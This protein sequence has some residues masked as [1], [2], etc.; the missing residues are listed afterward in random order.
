MNQ[1]LIHRLQSLARNSDAIVAVAVIGMLFLMV[2]PLNAFML[3]MFLVL[4]IGFSIGLLLI[5]INTKRV[6][7]FSV[8]PTVLLILTLFRLSLNVA[9]TR[10][11]LSHGHEGV[12]AAGKVIESFGNF[13][14]EGN[15]VVGL[16]VFVILVIINFIVITKGAGRISE[17][18]A[19]FTLDALPGKQMAIDADLNAGIIND[20]EAKRRRQEV[21]SEADFYGAMD[22][23]SKF[24]RGD[25]IAG[26]LVTIVNIIGGLI[27]GVVQKN[28]DVALAAKNYTLLTVGDGLVAQVPALIISTAAGLWVTRAGSTA[29]TFG[30]DIS[31]QLFVNEKLFYI[32]A[33]VLLLLGIVLSGTF[34]PFAALAGLVGGTGYLIK[35][36]KEDKLQK[37]A[38]NA[39]DEELSKKGKNVE[40][41]GTVESLSL[42]VG[43][44]LISIVDNKE[45]GD[46]LDRIQSLRKQFA[47]DLGI[48][49]PALNIRDNLQLKPGEYIVL[50]KGIEIG[51]GDLMVDHFMA[52]DP[53]GIT[54]RID[55]IETKEPVFGLDALWIHENN[56]ELA[57][58]AG[59]TVVD[60]STIIATHMTEVIRKNASE[61]VGRQEVQ[62]LIDI[63]KKTHP[64]VIDDL[65]PKEISLGQVVRVLQNLLREQVS[66]RDLVTILEALGDACLISKENDHLTESVRVA[67]GRTITRTLMDEN[68]ELPLLTFA[69]EIEEQMINSVQPGDKNMGAQFLVDPGLIKKLLPVLSEK[70]DDLSK[71]GVPSIL[72]VTPMIRPHVK[73]LL[74][75]FL[76]QITVLSHNEIHSQL[77][78]RS[79]GNIELAK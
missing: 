77:K 76:P 78:V 19:R 45:K 11:I 3:D 68:G 36:Y 53:G 21:Q 73:R 29:D 64:K 59:Y 72:L 70:V 63:V 17:V 28:M 6:L 20:Q 71:D 60:L 75:R 31:K 24:I 27:I 22:G 18:A 7:D 8:F 56:K 42:E 13:V 37:E 4:S 55:G 9:T 47:Q 1:G 16:I 65:I 26:I 43:Y 50:L 51:R 46:L 23:S 35:S 10:I 30:A 74:D 67:L 49:V 34:L 5:S 44:G 15:Y 14:V 12:A 58:L 25:A 32:L 61:L 62:D 2:M 40:A 69:R 79:V 41:T 33:S 48:I 38:S 57:Q 66:I 54:E 39:A 52:M